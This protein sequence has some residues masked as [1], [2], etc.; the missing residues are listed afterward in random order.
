M[1]YDQIMADVPREPLNKQADTRIRVWAGV[2]AVVS[3]VL[4]F[5]VLSHY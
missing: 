3:L 1:T 5:I 2:V 4:F